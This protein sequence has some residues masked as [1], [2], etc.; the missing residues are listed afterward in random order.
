MLSHSATATNQ[1]I[2]QYIEY[3]DEDGAYIWESTSDFIPVQST[4][5]GNIQ[6]GD[7]MSM[8]FDFVYNGPTNTHTSA[9]E[10]FFR[11][12]ASAANGNTCDGAHDAYPSFW[13]Y[14]VSRYISISLNDADS[15]SR[16]Y[17]LDEFGAISTDHPYHIELAFDHTTFIISIDDEN[18]T[19]SGTYDR[20]GA[21]DVG[22][23]VP[24][25]FMSNRYS[26][27]SS[28]PVGNGTFSSIII[29]SVIYTLS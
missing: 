11:I 21:T 13:V 22:N 24:V 14:S 29:K 20:N 23:E 26:P 6:I 3:R 5:F 12:G 9:R 15:C 17:D 28:Y 8:E 16:H 18:Q 19:W 7:E 1:T 25:W 27:T 10:N 4:S 2:N